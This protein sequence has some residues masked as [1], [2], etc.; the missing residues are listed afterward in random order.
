[1]YQRPVSFHH[2]QQRPQKCPQM[3]RQ[4]IRVIEF[5]K[6]SNKDSVTRALPS[7]CGRSE[8]PHI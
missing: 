2:R 8:D 3:A 1:M 6:P 4:S 5:A 7:L